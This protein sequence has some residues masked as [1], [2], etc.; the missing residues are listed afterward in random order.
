VEGAAG[1]AA[2][3]PGAGPTPEQIAKAAEA[4]EALRRAEKGWESVTLIAPR[5][6]KRGEDGLETL[7][8]QGFGVSVE[9][10]PEGA[11][12]I[13]GGEELGE[14]PLVAGV[15]CAP[16][17]EVTVRI[18]KAPRPAQERVLRCRPDTLV[19]LAVRLEAAGGR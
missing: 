7:P 9:S 16:G 11:R 1:R 12:V 19:K 10:V 18:E 15:R 8:F 6:A 13:V 14:T 3:P 4:Q 2:P 17:T 5:A